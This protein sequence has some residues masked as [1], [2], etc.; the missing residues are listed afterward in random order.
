MCELAQHLS[1]QGAW[2]RVEP[3]RQS[4]LFVHYVARS[5][6][7]DA[8]SHTYYEMHSTLRAWLCALLCMKSEAWRVDDR[9]WVQGVA[10]VGLEMGL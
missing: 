4:T 3:W 1:N 5:H 9:T 6:T 2:P 8:R 7:C 10:V